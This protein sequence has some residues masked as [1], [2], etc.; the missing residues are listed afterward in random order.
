M[1][2]FSMDY[3][4]KKITKKKPPPPPPLLPQLQTSKSYVR[5]PVCKTCMQGSVFEMLFELT[6][7]YHLILN[8]YSCY[9]YKYV[10]M[11]AA[12]VAEV[13]VRYDFIPTNK[14][15]L[16][17]L[18][19]CMCTEVI[20]KL[21]EC[22]VDPKFSRENKHLGIKKDLKALC[23]PVGNT[24]WCASW[25]TSTAARCLGCQPWSRRLWNLRS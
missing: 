1:L 22:D 4:I 19:I 6:I 10:T 21:Q 17:S 7:I 14:Y 9:F 25:Y 2:I 16:V 20:S 15:N 8:E 12:F 13:S 5:K 18:H 11:V 3:K 24:E 23:G